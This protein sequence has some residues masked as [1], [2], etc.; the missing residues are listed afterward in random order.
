M[1]MIVFWDVAPCCLVELTDVSEVLTAS[2]RTMMMEAESTSETPGK[3]LPDYPAQHP[4]RQSSS[5]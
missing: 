4:R 5:G 2:I 3:F 1:K